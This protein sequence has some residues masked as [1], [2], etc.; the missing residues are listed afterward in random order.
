V[1]APHA[2]DLTRHQGRAAISADKSPRARPVERTGGPPS[3]AT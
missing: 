3:R 1:Q 2:G